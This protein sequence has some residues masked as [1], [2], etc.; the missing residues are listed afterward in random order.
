MQA[1]LH[2]TVKEFVDMF[3]YRIR[4]AIQDATRPLRQKQKYCA[5]CGEH[6]ELQSSHPIGDSRKKI[7][8]EVILAR[9]AVNGKVVIDNLKQF[10]DDI[11]KAH[12][13]YATFFTF[14]C[15]P[16]HQKQDRLQ[17]EA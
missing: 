13:P 3:D 7:I 2:C 5:G 1:E 4:K 9:Y 15:Q 14:L 6:S 11:M 12:E 16:C 8:T 17:T 10:E